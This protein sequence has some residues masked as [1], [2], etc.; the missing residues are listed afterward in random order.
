[1]REA[2]AFPT[3]VTKPPRKRGRPA[4]FF[5]S[6]GLQMDGSG[7]IDRKSIM[8]AAFSSL[9]SSSTSVPTTVTINMKNPL[10]RYR[11]IL[12][13]LVILGVPA[14]SFQ[15][16]A[17]TTT[18]SGCGRGRTTT[19]TTTNNNNNEDIFLSRRNPT[20]KEKKSSSK[21]K[22]KSDWVLH[23]V[24]DDSSSQG[25]HRFTR[26]TEKSFATTTTAVRPSAARALLMLLSSS[27]AA[28]ASS[29]TASFRDT[30]LFAAADTT[31]A[32]SSFASSSTFSTALRFQEVPDEHDDGTTM[33]T[34]G[35]EDQIHE[36]SVF[37]ALRLGKSL[38]K[39]FREKQKQN[40]NRGDRLQPSSSSSGA[41]M[42]TPPKVEVEEDVPELQEAKGTTTPAELV[43]AADPE[44]ETPKTLHRRE[45]DRVVALGDDFSTEPSPVAA[46]ASPRRANDDAVNGLAHE[47]EDA[48]V[49]DGK[50][51]VNVE[52]PVVAVGADAGEAR[53][54]PVVSLEF[55][56]PLEVVKASAPPLSPELKL[57]LEQQELKQPPQEEEKEEEKQPTS[58]LE[59][60]VAA[61]A[62]DSASSL[63]APALEDAPAEAEP[64]SSASFM[65]LDSLTPDALLDAEPSSA[66]VA[67]ATSSLAS[68]TEPS[69]S[70]E[71]GTAGH[72]FVMMSAP[73]ATD[74]SENVISTTR[75]EE[76]SSAAS[77]AEEANPFAA[78]SGSGF[79]LRRNNS[80]MDGS[81]TPSSLSSSSSTALSGSSLMEAEVV[82][83]ED[84]ARASMFDDLDGPYGN[85]EDDEDE[86]AR[87]SSLFASGQNGTVDSM[88][89]ANLEAAFSASAS[90]VAGVNELPA[91]NGSFF[92]T[93]QE[94]GTDVLDGPDSL[95]SMVDLIQ[96]LQN[97]DGV[98][99]EVKPVMFEESLYYDAPT[100]LESSP[101]SIER[102]PATASS[103]AGLPSESSSTFGTIGQ[104][105]KSAGVPG[106]AKKSWAPFGQ[107]W[108]RPNTSGSSLPTEELRTEI[109]EGG[110]IKS[111]DSAW[112]DVPVSEDSATV[113]SKRTSWSPF[114]Q[115]WK[116][117]RT[118]SDSSDET[119]PLAD[120]KLS[121][122]HE[123]GPQDSQRHA[124]SLDSRKSTLEPPVSASASPATRSSAPNYSG[125]GTK[126]HAVTKSD[127]SYLSC[128]QVGTDTNDAVKHASNDE[129]I[130][131]DNR[132][133]SSTSLLDEEKTPQLR[134]ES[135]LA[136]SYHWHGDT[137]ASSVRKPHMA[138]PPS[139]K[140]ADPSEP[141][142]HVW[143]T[144]PKYPEVPNWQ[145][146]A[147]Y[148]GIRWTRG[149]RAD[150]EDVRMNDLP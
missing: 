64:S 109:S 98:P 120:P 66:S 85:D 35:I 31:K 118:E 40:Q 67:D 39:S 38:L 139:P 105:P 84:A 63:V 72:G 21:K 147:K 22:N 69:N 44:E 99:E 11:S 32:S 25:G 112:N 123:T 81:N 146:F 34:A 52:P 106:S 122:T 75:S 90:S 92:E 116:S 82:T 89:L 1:M 83:Y 49:G 137:W 95:D 113:S 140:N 135:P 138:K 27:E 37:L 150:N 45:G 41:V 18:S 24:H 60:S 133:V 6:A 62:S 142:P 126:H 80:T 65:A 111:M 28:S 3:F 114:S 129:S 86:E 15:L 119:P 121:V 145:S 115:S 100:I 68:E 29:P 131:T 53:V 74:E 87:F 102:G 148:S 16:P 143:Y 110:E 58:I 149:N 132:A 70:V 76:A 23:L 73:T 128:F 61:A 36:M 59:D 12:I 88:V 78:A 20:G 91:T 4:I 8:M 17:A 108:K 79:V 141:Y 96:G 47:V 43:A 13:A 14:W 7:T 54:P 107:N 104:I 9:M 57:R 144:I 42:M 5:P 19:T 51:A 125:F 46:A 117:P 103:I 48:K 77:S 56:R 134:G 94:G 136:L 2:R 130:Q 101:S 26:N 97:N 33:M 127:G 124:P 55:G 50:A 30:R 93:N 10:P 71:D